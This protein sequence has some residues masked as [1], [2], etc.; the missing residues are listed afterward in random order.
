VKPRFNGISEF[1]SR[2]ARIGLIQFMLDNGMTQTKLAAE[3]GVS[4]QAISKWLDKEETHPCNKNLDRLLKLAWKMD[5]NR[6]LKIL[7]GELD[8]FAKLLSNFSREKSI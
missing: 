1:V 3:I 4:Q 5:S 8:T 2:R 6:T 7:R